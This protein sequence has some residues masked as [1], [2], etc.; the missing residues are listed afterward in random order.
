VEYFKTLKITPIF[1]SFEIRLQK[2]FTN[3]TTG[4]ELYSPPRAG[5]FHFGSWGKTQEHSVNTI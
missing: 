4:T 5:R 3:Q 2:P 1:R